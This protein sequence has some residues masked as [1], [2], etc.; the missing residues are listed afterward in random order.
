MISP[1]VCTS[2]WPEAT[3]V[4]PPRQAQHT[5][6]GSRDRFPIV[7]RRPVAT[8]VAPTK[9]MD[10]HRHP[11]PRRCP[12]V[13]A[14]Y[15]RIPSG[16]SDGY[17]ARMNR[18]LALASAFAIVLPLALSGCG[19]KGPLVL[20]DAPA[21]TTVPAEPPAPEATPAADATPLPDATTPPPS[22]SGTPVR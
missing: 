10:W 16:R 17:T 21:E 8:S 15:A 4:P 19:N 1:T 18:R 5:S 22:T 12:S 2:D 13:V 20:S 14:E 3:V 7:V 11:W 6:D 9:A